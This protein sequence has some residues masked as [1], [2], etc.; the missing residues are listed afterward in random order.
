MFHVSFVDAFADVI[1]KLDISSVGL[2]S[3]EIRV[4]VECSAPA[5]TTSTNVVEVEGSNKG[6]DGEGKIEDDRNTVVSKRNSCAS[7]P[8]ASSSS[9][10]SPST[11]K[12]ETSRQFYKM[13]SRRRGRA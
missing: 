10:P 4:P 1:F 7:T 6:D 8:I 5:S 3:T 13:R 2:S 12:K 11:S 9:T